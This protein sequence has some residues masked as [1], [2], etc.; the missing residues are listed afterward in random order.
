[1]LTKITH[2][3]YARTPLLLSVHLLKE[4]S[5]EGNT[6]CAMPV[7]WLF[8]GAVSTGW[9]T[10][11]PCVF[12]QNS[13]LQVSVCLCIVYVLR[14]WMGQNMLQN[15]HCS[16]TLLFYNDFLGGNDELIEV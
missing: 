6:D 8:P 3:S 12:L 7:C 13:E 15:M 11:S 16:V 10:P 9:P 2:L 1:M 5:D 14:T 4:L